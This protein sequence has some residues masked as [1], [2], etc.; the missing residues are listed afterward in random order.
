VHLQLIFARLIFGRL[1]FGASGENADKG[2]GEQRG[3]TRET[4]IQRHRGS[5][6]NR[7][8]GITLHLGAKFEGCFFAGGCRE[9]MGSMGM[10]PAPSFGFRYC[11]ILSFHSMNYKA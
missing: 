4:C 5:S 10:F 9:E 2:C 7:V 6:E 3:E 1:V 11:W 8:H